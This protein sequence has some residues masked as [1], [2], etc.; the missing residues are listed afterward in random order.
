MGSPWPHGGHLPGEGRQVLLNKAA[1][2]G[3][4]SLGPRF[5]LLDDLAAQRRQ[6]VTGVS[7]R[8]GA[9]QCVGVFGVEAIT[10]TSPSGSRDPPGSPRPGLPGAGD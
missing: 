10:M 5:D 8:P 7:H 4:Q 9:L 2:A 1:E 6:G 3:S